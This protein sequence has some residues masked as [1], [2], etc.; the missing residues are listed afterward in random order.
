MGEVYRARDTRLGR[1]VAVKVLPSHLSSSP[2]VRQRFEREARTI[3]Q[4]SHP[5]ICALYDVGREG[6][7]EYL[8]MEYLEGEAL[9]DRLAR[10][11]LPLEQ[12]ARYGVQIADALDKAHRQGVVHRDLKPGNVML[13]KSGVKLLDFGLAKVLAPDAPRSSLTALP[14]VAGAANLTQEGTI[15]GTFQYMA[16]EQ[17]EG[18]E[19]DGRTDIFALGATLYEM[20]TGRKAFTGATQASLITAIMSSDPP[21]ISTIQPMTS[22]ALDRAVRK[23]LA[24]DPEDRWQNAA[25]LGSELKWIMEGGS[26]AGIPAP[27]VSR[28]RS[29]ERLIWGLAGALAG[30]VLASA[31]V[32]T[33]MRAARLQRRAGAQLAITL[34]AAEPM[35]LRSSHILAI[36]PDGSRVVY[37]GKRGNSRQLYLRSV[38]QWN[39]VPIPGTEG[40]ENPFF[41][42]DSQS[43]AFFADN[44]LKK[45]SLGGGLPATLCGTETVLGGTWGADDTIVMGGFTSGLWRVSAAGGTSRKLA[46]PDLSQSERAYLWPQLL[47][48]G[49][50]VLFTIWTGSSFDEAR[51]AVADLET[52]QH[53]TIFEGGTDARYLPTGHLLYERGGSLL[54]VPFDAKRL[55]TK[56]SPVTVLA[57]VLSGVTNGESHF[58]FSLDGSLAYLPGGVQV[59]ERTLVWVDRR[60][61][62]VPISETR[63]NFAEPALSPDGR[64]LAVT[65]QGAT[66]DIWVYEVERDI[67]TR[68]S[69]GLDDSTPAWTRDGKRVAWTSTRGGRPNIFWK[70]ADESGPEERLTTSEHTQYPQ[71]F[72][73]DGKVL[74]FLDVDPSTGDDLWILPLEGDRKPHPFLRTPFKEHWASFSPDGGWIAYA[75]DE[76]GREEVYVTPYPGPGGRVRI[77]PDGGSQS[78]WSPTGKELFYRQGDRMMAVAIQTKPSLT[79][80]KPALLFQEKYDEGYDVSSD[81]QRFIMIKKGEEQAT[82]QQINVVLGWFDELKSR[83]P[84]TK[85]Q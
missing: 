40:A 76:S 22:P 56:G 12:T 60:G 64:R 71:S 39:A 6:D 51:I 55:R 34:P 16:P 58:D 48:G 13:T 63:Q 28:R 41:S 66:F 26:Q 74:L 8:V 47:P 38:D 11:A 81:G 85:R 27:V 80:G 73:P 82:P 1:E 54:A 35:V 18:K 30:A 17:L 61:A 72:S 31:V 14:T 84:G 77:S 5:H 69:F 50:S 25:D 33:V 4:L 19:A 20:A 45:V 42:P 7:I 59:T 2:D 15:L 46:A 36:S 32:W 52:G 83:M 44:K 37:V 68:L 29:R 79:A 24:K 62:E 21:A 9:S 67:L 10:G 49:K 3:S 53:R 23:C 75:S 65:V 57:G 78:V 70:N 43:V